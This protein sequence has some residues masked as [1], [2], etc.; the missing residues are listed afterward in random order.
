MELNT[1]NTTLISQT[2]LLCIIICR[3]ITFQKQMSRYEI[4]WNFISFSQAKYPFLKLCALSA[5]KTLI[6]IPALLQVETPASFP[7]PSFPLLLPP[8]FKETLTPRRKVAVERSVWWWCLWWRRWWWWLC[9]QALGEQ[10]KFDR[11][12]E[13]DEKL[14]QIKNGMEKGWVCLCLCLC[15]MRFGRGRGCGKVGGCLGDFRFVFVFVI[16]FSLSLGLSLWIGRGR[17]CG[18]VSGSLGL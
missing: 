16:F 8:S 15:W 6:F 3:C 14:A 11:P 10:T 2:C 13:Q 12:E 4:P 9:S 17:G 18:K 7:D 1:F 5:S